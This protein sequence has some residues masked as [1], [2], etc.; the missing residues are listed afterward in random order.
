MIGYGKDQAQ[1]T[2]YDAYRD[3]P[4]LAALQPKNIGPIADGSAYGAALELPY[5][6]PDAPEGWTAK[7]G[8]T[9]TL[10]AALTRQSEDEK[11]QKRAELQAQFDFNFSPAMIEAE[12]NKA[13]AIEAAK[14][15]QGRE[16]PTVLVGELADQKAIVDE[17]RSLG[18]TLVSSKDSWADLRKAE[19]FSGFD[20]AGISSRISDLADRV[21]RS[22][23]GTAAPVSE[24]NILR[25]IIAG[26]KTVTPQQAG[27]LI[28]KFA[29]RE[30]SNAKSKAGLA[31]SGDISGAFDAPI[32]TSRVPEG[33]ISTGRTYKGKPAYQNS[34]GQMWVED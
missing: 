19:M 10:L 20:E 12:A 25:K 31:L 2:A 34:S 29:E 28:L 15:G 21:L 4:L 23:T 7:Q 8:K 27:N 5:V 16:I 32:E 13:G 3:S 6:S 11:A 18:K 24:Q 30:A 17:A 22:R 33:F 9:D 1:Q 26:D 14:K